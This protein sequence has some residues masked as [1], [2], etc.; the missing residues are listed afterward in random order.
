MVSAMRLDPFHQNMAD[1]SFEEAVQLSIRRDPRYQAEAYEF[2]R[3]ALHVAVKQFC[4]GDEG[5]HVGGRDL[6]EG[7]RSHALKEYGPMALFILRQWGVQQGIDVGHIV[8][9]LISAGYFGKSD[10]DSLDDFADG[11]DFDVAFT[12]P[13]LPQNGNFL[14]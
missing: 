5:Q 11:Y 12:T 7:V 10:G 8:Y 13:F 1:I 3:T 2:V 4:N 9:N 6:L 14:S